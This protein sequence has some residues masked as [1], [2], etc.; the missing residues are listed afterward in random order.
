M[1][2]LEEEK[3]QTAF[4]QGKKALLIG[5]L[6]FIGLHL[7]KK[8]S[9]LG[10]E[11]TILDKNTRRESTF[12]SENI[13]FI[14]A[15]PLDD[16]EA[17]EAYLEKADF[18]FNLIQVKEEDI[19]IQNKIVNFNLRILLACVRKGL[20]PVLVHF[21]SRL[22]YAADA[23]LP[24]TELSP[25]RPMTAYGLGKMLSESYY[26][27]FGRK[28]G[29]KT[30][31]LRIS[32]VYGPSLNRSTK[33]KGIMEVLLNG[34]KE[35]NFFIHEN[36]NRYKDFVYVDDFI[37]AIISCMREK[38]CYGEVF[39]I[40]SGEKIRFID[41]AE[42]IKKIFEY[43]EDIKINKEE[44]ISDFSFYLD[45]SKIKKFI[46]WEIKTDLDSGLKKIKLEM[47]KKT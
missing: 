8:L 9:S 17:F 37:S 23:P 5:G 46:S 7:A 40:S 2:K 45:N 25:L 10:T 43:S 16:F 27:F 13:K 18:V 15:N 44:N 24:L 26:N 22:E 31:C 14:L 34:I 11:V 30:I 19:E 20:N 12:L 1:T 32:N 39:N 36:I 21:G 29:L 3:G 47:E 4:Y 6:G 35:D 38:K 42:K 41:L 28:Y 33:G